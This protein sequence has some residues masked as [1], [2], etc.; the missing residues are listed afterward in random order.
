MDKFVKGLTSAVNVEGLGFFAGVFILLTIL[1]IIR[2]RPED[3]AA[4]IQ[5]EEPTTG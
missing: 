1:S 2:W 5:G 4:R 3:V